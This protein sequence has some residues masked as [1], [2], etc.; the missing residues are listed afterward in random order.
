MGSARL[1]ITRSETETRPTYRLGAG[2]RSTSA[3]TVP[4]S[5]RYVTPARQ[6][7][8]RTMGPPA[9][10]IAASP[11]MLALTS[12]K[13]AQAPTPAGQYPT[14]HGLALGEHDISQAVLQFGRHE[15]AD[16]GGRDERVEAKGA[17]MRNRLVHAVRRSSLRSFK[18]HGHV[19]RRGL[20]PRQ[21]RRRPPG[22]RRVRHCREEGR[23]GG[24]GIPA[25][26][27]C[28]QWGC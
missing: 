27:S 23:R 28:S 13:A 9:G 19:R 16:L 14:V 4:I 3:E 8:P 7:G 12:V 17:V 1:T 25:S 5:R 2:V 22:R 20:G 15:V 26:R 24:N 6:D 21:E 10:S 18:R 11:P